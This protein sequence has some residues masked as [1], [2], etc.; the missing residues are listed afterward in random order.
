M[1]LQVQEQL[2]CSRP[3]LTSL[4]PHSS[5]RRIDKCLDSKT[6]RTDEQVVVVT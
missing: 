3:V 4:M 6:S 2:T 1:G 5:Q